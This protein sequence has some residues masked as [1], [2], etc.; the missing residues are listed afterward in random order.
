MALYGV[1][2]VNFLDGRCSVHDMV[3]YCPT[4][5]EKSVRLGEIEAFASFTSFEIEANLLA[6]ATQ[7]GAIELGILQM[8][9]NRE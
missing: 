9:L 7:K 5:L 4:F 1:V 6:Q 8:H 2:V 3:G